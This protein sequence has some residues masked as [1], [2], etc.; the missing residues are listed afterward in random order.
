MN[1]KPI[2]GR[3]TERHGM[4]SEAAKYT[5]S[6]RHK[7][8]DLIGICVPW[9]VCFS[10]PRV[11]NPWLL[12]CAAL[13]AFL[14]FLPTFAHAQIPT[15]PAI[16]RAAVYGAAL[17]LYRYDTALPLAV[18]TTGTQALG[19]ARL[20]RFSYLSTHG[21]RVPALLFTPPGASAIRP[22]PC[23][24]ILHG[25]GGSKEIM[26]GMALSVV[27]A[28][29]AALVIDEY[30]QGERGP[31]KTPAGQEA[32]A[33]AATVSQ[34]A[35]DVRR[36]LDYLA[37]RP[38]IDSRRVGLAGVSLGAMIGT[39]T[40]GVEP[41]LKAAVL[42]SGG[43]NWGVILRTLSS[44]N[45]TVGDRSTAAFKASDWAKLNARLAPVDPLT[46]APRIAPRPVL[47]LGGRKDTTIVP[48]SQQEL[49]DALNQPKRI[50]WYP[51]YGHVP[52]PE[53]VYPAMQTFFRAKL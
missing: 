21:Q 12:P 2:D 49:F 36:G 34:T 6:R 38:D 9:T 31:L 47:M 32:A 18:K 50:V 28:G 25:L 43:G 45:A 16:D 26:A 10:E 24:V 42:V 19:A 40:C 20:Q 41:R 46:F 44:R 5:V 23:I 52:P 27:Q 51:Q 30:G 14:A 1:W 7:I 33:L 17:P 48:Q 53:V 8:S 4:N 29:D 13:A 3:G 39:V 35:V 15:A 22:V 37:T 11:S